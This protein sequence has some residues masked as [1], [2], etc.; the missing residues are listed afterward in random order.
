MLQCGHCLVGGHLLLTFPCLNN[1]G[2]GNFKLMTLEKEE[3]EGDMLCMG[4]FTISPTS[5]HLTPGAS[6]EL[7]VHVHVVCFIFQ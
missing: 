5:F 4:V 7:K 1:G 6:I 2:E 3:G